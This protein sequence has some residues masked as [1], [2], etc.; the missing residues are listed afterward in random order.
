MEDDRCWLSPTLPAEG[1]GVR[2]KGGVCVRHSFIYSF[3]YLIIF[4]GHG[5][6]GCTAVEAGKG[7]SGWREGGAPEGIGQYRGKTIVLKFDGMR[8]LRALPCV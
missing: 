6:N 4:S 2:I 3:A 1:A 5:L 8:S 7:L